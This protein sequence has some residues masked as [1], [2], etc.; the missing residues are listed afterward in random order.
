MKQKTKNNLLPKLKSDPMV[1]SS[2]HTKSANNITQHWG[3]KQ[4]W[5]QTKVIYHTCVCVNTFLATMPQGRRHT[6]HLYRCHLKLCDGTQIKSLLQALFLLPEV[7]YSNLRGFC[8][9][10]IP[11]TWAHSHANI[12]TCT[13]QSPHGTFSESWNSVILHLICYENTTKVLYKHIH[14]TEKQWKIKKSA[15]KIH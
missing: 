15:F 13:L 11:R 10:P 6:L 14:H 1:Q 3:M 5:L 12:N 9:Q 4:Q 2:K 7:T 8:S